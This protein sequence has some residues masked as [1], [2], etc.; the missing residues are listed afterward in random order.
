MFFVLTFIF[1][2]FCRDSVSTAHEGKIIIFA[3]FQGMR[4]KAQLVIPFVKQTL[5]DIKP[6]DS[7]FLW[8]SWKRHIEDSS[9]IFYIFQTPQDLLQMLQHNAKL[10]DQ[11]WPLG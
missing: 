5:D 8:Q 1:G 4:I 11:L 7:V 2:K 10:Q 6:Y 3:S 9:P